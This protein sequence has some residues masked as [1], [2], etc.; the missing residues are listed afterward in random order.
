MFLNIGSFLV[1]RQA[2]A[3]DDKGKAQEMMLEFAEQAPV[4]NLVLKNGIYE[5]IDK[6]LPVSQMCDRAMLALKSIKHK[7]SRQA[8]SWAAGIHPDL[9]GRSG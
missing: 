4:P 7:H 2:N 8:V 1:I 3:A 6:T 5:N 9:G